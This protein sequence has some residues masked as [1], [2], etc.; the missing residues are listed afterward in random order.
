MQVRNGEVG[1]QVKD[2]EVTSI[3]ENID[4]RHLVKSRTL[5]GIV[6]MLLKDIY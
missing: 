1:P 4:K 6:S 5:G 3:C 2:K